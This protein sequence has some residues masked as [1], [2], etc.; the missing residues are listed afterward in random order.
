MSI[1][2]LVFRDFISDNYELTIAYRYDGAYDQTVYSN[3]ITYIPAQ[4]EELYGGRAGPR[5]PK[6][7]DMP[8]WEPGERREIIVI[9]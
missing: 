8:R 7:V 2:S 3:N 4:P 9:D 5:H 6:Y 1:P